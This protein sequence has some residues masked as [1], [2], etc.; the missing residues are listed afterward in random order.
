MALSLTLQVQ[1]LKLELFRSDRT[2]LTQKLFI[3]T[4]STIV[5]V[6]FL[7]FVFVVLTDQI[8]IVLNRASTLEDFKYQEGKLKAYKKRGCKNFTLTF[9]RPGLAWLLPLSS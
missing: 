3:L 8:V 5:L 7:L 6:P 4:A 1:E 9:G 2:A